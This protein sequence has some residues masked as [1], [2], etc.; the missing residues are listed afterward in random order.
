VVL[1]VRVTT[2]AILEVVVLV[3][4]QQTVLSILLAAEGNPYLHKVDPSKVVLVEVLYLGKGHQPLN[5]AHKLELLVLDMALVV[6][7]HI[8]KT[9]VI[10][11]AV[12]ELL[13]LYSLNGNGEKYATRICCSKL[14]NC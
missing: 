10:F 14:F 3:V 1:V 2:Q 4:R 9:P 6:V 8:P 11:Q 12:L 13:D 5:I 7:G